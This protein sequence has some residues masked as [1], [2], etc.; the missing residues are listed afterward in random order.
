MNEDQI[1]RMSQQVA[2]AAV[3]D[4]VQVRLRQA[5]QAAVAQSTLPK[6]R[7]H[8]VMALVLSYPKFALASLALVLVIGVYWA[9]QQQQFQR[10]AAID[11]AL[12]SSD[13]PMD[14]LLE[15]SLIEAGE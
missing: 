5:R 8:G 12:L 2:D 3:P 15:P 9:Q 7:H 14:L 4:T 6:A 13:V 11:I 10:D 1:G